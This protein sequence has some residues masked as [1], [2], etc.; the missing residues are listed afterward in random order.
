[1]AGPIA[2]DRHRSP[3]PRPRPGRSGQRAANPGR[4]PIHSCLS[5][6][7]RPPKVQA[8]HPSGRTGLAGYHPQVLLEHPGAH[9]GCAAL[10]GAPMPMRMRTCTCIMRVPCVRRAASS[11]CPVAFFRARGLPRNASLCR[12]ARVGARGLSVPISRRCTRPSPKSTRPWRTTYRP[13]WRPT[14]A[15]CMRGPTHPPSCGAC[16][17]ATRPR[18]PRQHGLQRT[19][20]SSVAAER[21]V[22]GRRAACIRWRAAAR[23]AGVAL[24]HLYRSCS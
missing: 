15:S 18:R 6:S 16:S 9:V 7:S 2:H 11:T 22:G 23:S 21:R 12:P 17:L 19:S 20:H 5:S 3:R 24:R 1:L 8:E 13:T 14:S 4:R 10:L